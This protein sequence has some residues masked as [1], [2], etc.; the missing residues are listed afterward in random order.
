MMNHDDVARILKTIPGPRPTAEEIY[1]DV[2]LA[3]ILLSEAIG[4]C[5]NH[6]RHN[7]QPV[8]DVKRFVENF[9]GRS[10]ND[11]ALTIAFRMN[12]LQIKRELIGKLPPLDGFEEARQ[13]W[14]ERQ[15]KEQKQ[16]EI[17]QKQWAEFRAK[18]PS[19]RP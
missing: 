19:Y 9:I 14:S 11:V 4:R 15:A 8:S 12:A 5:R 7:F 17:E 10:V 18:H 3:Q 6:G 13:L 2:V 16:I 1:P